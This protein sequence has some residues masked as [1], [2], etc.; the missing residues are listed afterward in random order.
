MPRACPVE[1]HVRR[2]KGQKQSPAGCHGLGPWRLTFV[3]TKDRNKARQDA[4]GLSR[5]GSRSSLQRTETKPG[6]MPRAC[7]VEAHVCCYLAVGELPTRR[8]HGTSPWY[9]PS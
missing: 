2:Y 3:A 6:R 9:L 8:L 4:T 1:A 5:G 7:P